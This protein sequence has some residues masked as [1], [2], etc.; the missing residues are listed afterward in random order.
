MRKALAQRE[1]QRARFVGTFERFGEKRGWRGRTET[2]VLL[3]D[4]CDAATGRA[5][6]DHLWLGLTKEFG[7][8]NLQPGDRV[9]FDARVK[10]YLKGYMGRRDDVY[11]K[12]VEID[13]KLS[14]PTQ[15]RKLRPEGEPESNTRQLSLL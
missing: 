15:V 10:I 12:P 7:R 13:Y 6:C 3:R 5:V 1:E 8:L 11:D 14:H 2:T 4:I 9:A